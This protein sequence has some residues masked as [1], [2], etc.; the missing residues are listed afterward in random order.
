MKITDPT[1]SGGRSPAAR[2]RGF[3]LIELLV[4][5]AIIA[6]LAALLLPTLGKARDR[7]Y[8]IQCLNNQKQLLLTWTLYKDDNAGGL[9]SNVRGTPP[10]GSGLN[11]V[12]STVHGATPGFVETASFTD[13]SRA[14]FANYWRNPAV[15]GCP[16]E[17]SIYTV[18][19]QPVK[20]LRSYS[21]NDYMNGGA[22]QYAP[23]PPVFFYTRDSQFRRAS[24]LFVFI[25]AEPQSI[26]YT[27][28]E[29]P[30]SDTGE[31]FTAP[32]GLHSQR[33]TGVISF[34]DAHAETHRWKKP[35]V[36]P[37]NPSS[38]PNPHP[39]ASDPA[40]TRYVRIRSHHLL[41]P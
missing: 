22:Q 4:V 5:I 10:A 34:A 12:S 21:M 19:A 20:K 13:P 31:F 16:A 36:R 8:R 24:E 3:T 11:W 17:R 14:A 39:S 41:M 6:L 40:D 2:C 25:E 33:R 28:F 38:N 32:G 7:A 29:I 37:I 35:G 9:P 27:P 15:Y 26:C 30:T 18:G 23:V 1:P